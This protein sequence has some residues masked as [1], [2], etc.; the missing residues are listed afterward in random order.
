MSCSEK[1]DPSHTESLIN[2]VFPQLIECGCNNNSAQW[3]MSNLN[4][5]LHLQEAEEAA[6]AEVLKLTQE[7]EMEEAGLLHFDQQEVTEEDTQDNQV[8]VPEEAENALS[9]QQSY[10]LYV[11]Q[12]GKTQQA[13]EDAN[14]VTSVN[15]GADD[16]DDNNTLLSEED[17]E[18][19]SDA[20]DDP[21]RR[22]RVR[23][24]T[25]HSFTNY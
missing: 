7:L 12:S 2:N 23:H 15:D 5:I 19:I 6:A 17:N 16:A 24:R 20:S 14:V 22:R 21:L 4:F 3:K 1:K 13:L 25:L 9:D 10:Q 8:Q 11:Q 18:H